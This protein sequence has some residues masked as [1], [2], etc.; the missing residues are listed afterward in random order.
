MAKSKATAITDAALDAFIEQAEA[1]GDFA[2]LFRQ[3]SD[4]R[5]VP[6]DHAGS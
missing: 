5:H 3:L 1:P 4:L 2:A 6:H